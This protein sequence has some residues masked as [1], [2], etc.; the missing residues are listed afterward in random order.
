MAVTKYPYMRYRT[1]D[2]C[3][4]NKYARYDIYAL[5]E[6]CAK[7]MKNAFGYEINCSRRTILD[8]IDFMESSDGWSIKLKR[9]RDG[10]KVF[11]EYEDQDFSIFNSELSESDRDKLTE[12]MSTLEKFK[13]LPCFEWVDD[14]LFKLDNGFRQSSGSVI[15]FETA[16]SLKG[17]EFVDPLFNFICNKQ[18]VKISYRSFKREEQDW[19]IHPYL[20]KQY[21]KR[22][23]LFGKNS[24]KDGRIYNIPLDRILSV[25]ASTIPYDEN[26]GSVEKLLS[27]VYGVTIDEEKEAEDIQLK[28]SEHRLPY[29]LTKK[30]H[31]SQ[32]LIDEKN[33]IIQITVI[34]N[35]ELEAQILQYGYDVEVLAPQSLREQIKQK[36]AEMYAKYE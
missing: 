21:N 26:D 34:P 9:I 5:M 2:R 13:G 29:V 32:E 35:K 28:F 4:R 1:L 30:L 27:K 23:F 3:F 19:I 22:W 25:E 6:E 18:A 14:I 12:A 33:R 20:I 15:E 8:D 17:T 36:I 7:T 10:H 16:P 31:S 24:S 11:F